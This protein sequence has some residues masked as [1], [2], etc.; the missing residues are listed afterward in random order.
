MQRILFLA[1]F[2]MMS[3]GVAPSEYTIHDGFLFHGVRLCIP[4]CSLRLQLLT[5]LHRE[6]HVRRDR[7]L[8]LVSSSYFWPSLTVTSKGLS[9]VV[10]LV[11]NIKV[12]PRMLGSI[13]LYRFLLSRGWILAWISLLGFHVHIR[14]LI[15]SLLSSI[16]FRRCPI[17]YPA[18]K[19]L[20]LS[21]SRCFSFEK[22][23]DYTV[24]Q[25]PLSL[26]VILGFLDTFGDL[27]G[28]Y[29]VLR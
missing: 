10:S 27:Y 19:R 7:T 22:S 24:Y 20:M 12:L 6:G 17:S 2:M 13:C 23:I 29:W 26:I 3:R 16:D 9:N 8:P 18:R 11:N 5:E 4:D 21:R 28:S 14:V 1:R 15:Q 25:C